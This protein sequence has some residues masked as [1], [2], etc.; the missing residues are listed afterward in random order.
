M[1]SGY[2]RN[3]LIEAS[4]HTSR[5]PNR[6]PAFSGSFLVAM[7]SRNLLG[8]TLLCIAVLAAGCSGSGRLRYDSPQ[9]A[10]E[11]GKEL[12]DVGKYGRAIEY[13]Q[14]VFDYGRT[15]EHAA[16]AQF[17]LAKS[18]YDNGQYI[19]SSNEYTRFIDIYR[20]D[21][22]VE[23]AEFE[24]AMSYFMQSPK[25]ELDQTPTEQAITYFQLFLD[26]YPNSDRKDDAEM[27]IRDLREKLAH[28]EF[29]AAE[30]YERREIYQAAAL[31]FERVFDLYPDT[32]WADDALVGAIRTYILF[33]EQSVVSRQEERLQAAVDHYERLTQLFQ[34]SPLLRT[35]EQLYETA[36]GRLQD[37]RSAS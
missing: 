21:P 11:K 36:I 14:G 25:Y 33:A 30:L 28:K 12:Y 9:E 22:R 3:W 5:R 27:R 13:F 32:R 7:V 29:A 6:S 37:L 16:D 2:L 35:A 15:T 23:E 18:Y 26:R 17:Y 10:F 24:R 20:N 1:R 34:D 4:Y 8:L 31:S 19:L